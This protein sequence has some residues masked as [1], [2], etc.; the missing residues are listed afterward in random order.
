MGEKELR[1]REEGVE[2]KSYLD[3]VVSVVFAPSVYLKRAREVAERH[4]IAVSTACG[5]GMGIFLGAA[6]VDGQKASDDSLYSHIF[7][8][9]EKR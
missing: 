8:T 2:G 1:G 6:L 9:R 7:N 4:P 5:V 3:W